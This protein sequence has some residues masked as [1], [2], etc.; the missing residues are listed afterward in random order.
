L[1]S[2]LGFAFGLGA[3]LLSAL[4]A[5]SEAALGAGFGSELGFLGGV[6]AA[7]DAGSEEEVIAV[8]SPNS[9][10]LTWHLV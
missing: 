2:F 3:G 8:S 1:G 4:G 6:S 5:E 10:I 9:D 7:G